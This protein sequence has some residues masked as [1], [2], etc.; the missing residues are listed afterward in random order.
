MG[1]RA[2]ED[3]EGNGLHPLTPKAG[4]LEPYP[5]S[6]TYKSRKVL[7]SGRRQIERF[8]SSVMSVLRGWTMIGS[9]HSVPDLARSRSNLC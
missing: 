1:T 4:C 9:L 8:G 2:G 5:L 6:P 7:Q 3:G